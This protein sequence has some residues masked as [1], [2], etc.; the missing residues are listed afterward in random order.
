[1]DFTSGYHRSQRCYTRCSLSLIATPP[2]PPFGV[3]TLLLGNESNISSQTCSSASS[4]MFSALRSILLTVLLMLVTSPLYQFR[5]VQGSSGC[6]SYSTV[7]LRCGISKM[8]ERAVQRI[9]LEVGRSKWLV[10]C[11]V[12]KLHRAEPQLAGLMLLLPLTIF[13]VPF[14]N[15]PVLPTCAACLSNQGNAINT[16]LC[17]G[18]PRPSRCLGLL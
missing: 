9:Q 14:K 13:S 8:P 11:F 6:K 15:I 2:K 7:P 3:Q 17:N 4:L 18:F 1:M 12:G 5:S 16:R 10:H